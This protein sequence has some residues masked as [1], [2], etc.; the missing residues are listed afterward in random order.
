MKLLRTKIITFHQIVC[1]YKNFDEFNADMDKMQEDR[2][3]FQGS[4]VASEGQMEVTWE[5][6]VSNNVVIPRFGQ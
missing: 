3:T 5:K 1:Q 6:V 4:L 2:W